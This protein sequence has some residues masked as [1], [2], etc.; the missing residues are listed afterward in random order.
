M[1]SETVLECDGTSSNICNELDGKKYGLNPV[2]ILT[3]NPDPEKN[4]FFC[5]GL[6][7]LFSLNGNVN[8]L[9]L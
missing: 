3:K 4:T 5:S 1:I 8:S 9:T 6:K 2:Q 7:S